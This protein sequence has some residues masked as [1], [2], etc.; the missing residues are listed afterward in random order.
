MSTPPSPLL[1]NFWYLALPGARLEAGDVVP[2]TLLG[3][4]ILLGRTA[5]GEPFAL[6]DICPHRGMPLRYG[7]FDGCEVT[8][9]YHGWKFD[10]AGRCTDIPSLTP[11]QDFGVSRV[12]VRSYPCCDVQGNVWVFLA[13]RERDQPDPLPEPPELPGVGDEAPRIAFSM[14][15]P[16]SAD[17]AAF[18]LMDPTHAAFV[19]TS[20]WW[21][22]DAHLLRRK[23]KSFEPAPLGWRMVRHELPPEHRL[24]KLLGNPVTTEIAYRLPGVRIEHIRGVKHT[25]LS[26]TAITPITE[27]ETE[28]HQCLYWTLPFLGILTP[29]LRRL[30][31]RFLKQDR[32]VV[33]RQQEGLAHDPALMLIDDADT[34][35]KWY[36]RLKR[37]W[38]AAEEEGRPFENPLEPAT[39]R[40]MS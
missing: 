24:Y 7:R 19:H 10:S 20:W 4:P 23:E 39:L 30:A 29:V 16:C 40:W 9:C 15:F 6:R 21:K 18:G 36:A 38:I 8:C 33:V 3:E 2:R 34:Q 37:E 22:K 32:D 12:R 11:E 1:W 13:R 26:L 35:A 17:H 5:D 25:A 14:D 31:R 27:T 28:V